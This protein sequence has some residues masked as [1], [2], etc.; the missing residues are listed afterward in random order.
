MFFNQKGTKINL[1]KLLQ[2]ITTQKINAFSERDEPDALKANFQYL[3]L[4]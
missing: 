3:A 1:V 2:K 4:S